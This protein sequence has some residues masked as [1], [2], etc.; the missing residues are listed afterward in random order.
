M[1]ADT[2][3][4]ITMSATADTVANTVRRRWPMDVGPMGGIDTSTGTVVKSRISS[5][6]QKGPIL[7]TRAQSLK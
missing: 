4:T 5:K 1:Y 7:K 6:F 3:A 2:V